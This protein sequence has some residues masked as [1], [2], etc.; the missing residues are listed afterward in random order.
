MEYIFILFMY[1]CEVNDGFIIFLILFCPT[2]E[3]QFGTALLHNPPAPRMLPSL[4][5]S[6]RWST[7]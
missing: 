3:R 7:R 4:S 5:P 1:M 2:F 6:L